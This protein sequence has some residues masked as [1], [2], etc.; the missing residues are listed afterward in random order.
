MSF[1]LALLL[2]FSST[3]P[4]NTQQQQQIQLTQQAYLHTCRVFHVSE[5]DRST[6]LAVIQ[7]HKSHI[8][9]EDDDDDD[10]K[11]QNYSLHIHMCIEYFVFDVCV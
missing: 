11:L 5:R 10:E 6:I 4:Y 8:T 1:S 2:L 9:K 3:R 7:C